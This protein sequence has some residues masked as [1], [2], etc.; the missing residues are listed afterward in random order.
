MDRLR[1]TSIHND[2][3]SNFCFLYKVVLKN[4]NPKIILTGN[5]Y[6]KSTNC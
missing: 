1:L 2:Q 6:F 4:K 5:R 3:K